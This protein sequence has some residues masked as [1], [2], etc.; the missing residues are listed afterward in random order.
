MSDPAKYRSKEE[1]Q[2]MRQ[3][4]DPIENLKALLLKEGHAN[5]ADLKELD[6]EIK[7]RVLESADYA[8]SSPEPSPAELYK[9]VVAS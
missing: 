2:K 5:E 8:Q 3:E 4:R 1:V 7:S 9:D 6:K